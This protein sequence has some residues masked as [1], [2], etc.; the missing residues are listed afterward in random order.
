MPQ[1]ILLFFGT[2][3]N[4]GFMSPK[5]KT[6]VVCPGWLR[7]GNWL[8]DDR[9][10]P[11]ND[12]VPV[13]RHPEG[14]HGLNVQNILGTVGRPDAEVEVLLQRN[15]DKASHRILGRVSQRVG[16][17]RCRWRRLR[18]HLS[19][20]WPNRSVLCKQRDSAQEKDSRDQAAS[21]D[22]GGLGNPPHDCPAPPD[23]VA[24]FHGDT[25][26]RGAPPKAG[27]Q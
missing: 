9:R 18:S 2:R 20:L 12:E 7:N 13:V 16:V 1:I 21:I 25:G 6:P 10:N 23:Q 4:E 8:I 24:K 15:A 17:H 19:S 26:H 3:K 11:A 5:P 27:E 14:N 22:E